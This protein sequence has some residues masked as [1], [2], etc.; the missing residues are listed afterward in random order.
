MTAKDWRG[1]MPWRAVCVADSRGRQRGRGYRP[2]RWRSSDADSESAAFGGARYRFCALP[3]LRFRSGGVLS[4]ERCS[5]FT[6]AQPAVAAL[7]TAMTLSVQLPAMGGPPPPPIPFAL[8]SVAP[9][10]GS[11]SLRLNLGPDQQQ[12]L[13][14]QIDGDTVYLQPFALP[15]PGRGVADAANVVGKITAQAEVGGRSKPPASKARCAWA[16]PG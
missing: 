15:L 16:P 8:D 14:A 6:V 10:P 1:P 3:G 9:Q 7:P 13:W 2:S 5:E 4:Y 12:R 11:L